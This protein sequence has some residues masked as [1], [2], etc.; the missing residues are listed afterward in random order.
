MKKRIKHLLIGILSFLVIVIT[1]G[2]IPACTSR[3]S[4]SSD[5]P[6]DLDT[7]P[8]TKSGPKLVAH[9][10]YSHAY[11]ENTET[12]FRAAAEL[13]FYGIETDLHKTKDG[14]YV[15]SHNPT[16]KYA[17]GAE[18]KIADFDRAELVSQPLKNVVTEKEEFLCTFEDYLRACKAGNKVAVIELKVEKNDPT[19]LF[20]KD[21]LEILDIVDEEYDR[22]NV[23]FISFSYTPLWLLKSVDSSIETQYLSQ[24]ENDEKFDR[25]LEDGISIDVKQTILTQELVDTFHSAGLLVN[26]WTVDERSD[27]ESVTKMGVDYITTNVFYED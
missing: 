24:T 27:I 17:N 18:K 9:R 13:S 11:L 8:E 19:F 25:C 10:G 23:C 12:A 5:N 21:I 22:R 4:S 26:V 7:N 16:V 6:S 1:M 2:I 14:H 20:K 3:S 15:C